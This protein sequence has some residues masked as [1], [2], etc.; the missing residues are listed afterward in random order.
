MPEFAWSERADSGTNHGPKGRIKMANVVKF[1]E[2]WPEYFNWIGLDPEMIVETTIAKRDGGQTLQAKLGEFPVNAIEKFIRY[3][4]QRVFNDKIGGKDTDAAEKVMAAR[5]MMQAYKE[6]R[7][8]RA[9]RAA[10]DPVWAMVKTLLKKSIREQT[11]DVWKQIKDRDDLD[12]LLEAKFDSMTE[13]KREKIEAI[14]QRD[15][16]RLE[17]REAERRALGDIGAIE[18]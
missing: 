7:V 13:E 2:T 12:E 8:G 1:D 16:K 15:I 3:G 10:A 14:A 6:G 4:F 17:E 5:E 11:P 9:I 18:L